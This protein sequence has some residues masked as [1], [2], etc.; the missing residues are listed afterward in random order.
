[1]STKG[2]LKAG[3]KIQTNLTGASNYDLKV[4]GVSVSSATSSMTL[5]PY[6][7]NQFYELTVNSGAVSVSCYDALINGVTT[8]VALA[9]LGGAQVAG[10]GEARYL[11]DQ[12]KIIVFDGVKWGGG[13]TPKKFNVG[14]RGMFATSGNAGFTATGAAYT[15]MNEIEFGVEFDWVRFHLV[16]GN[17]ST[18]TT[19]VS[20]VASAPAIGDNGTAL[21]WATVSFSD[22]ANVQPIP[23]ATASTPVVYAIPAV[24]ATVGANT[25]PQAVNNGIWS[26]WV[27][28]PSVARSDGKAGSILHIR[29]ALPT[30]AVISSIGGAAV[31][32]FDLSA[33][34]L[35]WRQN[36]DAGDL[37]TTTSSALAGATQGWGVVDAVEIIPRKS[38]SHILEVGDSISRGQ[39]WIDSSNG[40]VSPGHL[41][42]LALIGKGV[43][44][45]NKAVSG[46]KQ[47]A[48]I[49]EARKMI[50]TGYCSAVIIPVWTPNDNDGTNSIGQDWPSL[51]AFVTWAKSKAVKVILRSAVPD[52][53]LS[54]NKDNTRKSLNAKAKA[55]AQSDK[56][57]FYLDTDLVISD[58]ASP[59]RQQS[60]YSTGSDG[61]HP[62]A[63][64][65]TASS[66]VYK[67]LMMLD[68]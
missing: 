53:A 23:P 40:F 44:Y 47:A 61:R 68:L 14:G 2:I 22:A 48:Y 37:A 21:T 15:L 49:L 27:K 63:T 1:M 5:G 26:D 55:L 43:S 20:K 38:C 34:D 57:I 32:N 12:N 19:V 24:D 42:A 64:G 30:G 10:V 60:I 6:D 17:S 66:T 35:H 4:G 65:I 28:V 18:L 52:Y 8:S 33:G 31:A 51:L 29:N 67:S 39:G 9:D 13:W 36:M 54:L 58:G 41:A 45:T 7:D 62:N 46:R 50:T 25:T 11:S 3:N 59:A 16:N 56:D